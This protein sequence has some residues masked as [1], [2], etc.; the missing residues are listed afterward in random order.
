MR[1]C[2]TR[3]DSSRVHAVSRASSVSVAQDASVN[4]LL[5]GSRSNV[6]FYIQPPAY[7]TVRL[8]VWLPLR[9]RETQRERCRFLFRSAQLLNIAVAVYTSYIKAA[10]GRYPSV[11][12]CGGPKDARLPDQQVLYASLVAGQVSGEPNLQNISDMIHGK[13][14]QKIVLLLPGAIS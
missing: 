3:A 9:V 4:F 1:V 13:H 8:R 6:R 12:D 7:S 2:S 10:H 5:R 14:V 11:C